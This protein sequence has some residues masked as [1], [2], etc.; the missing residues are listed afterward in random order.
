[1]ISNESHKYVGVVS[2]YD[3]NKLMTE[4]D[5]FE[6]GKTYTALVEFDVMFGYKF[7]NDTKFTV[8]GQATSSY[9]QVFERKICFTV[10]S[11]LGD[12][13]S[14]GVLNA[15]DLIELKK[16]LLKESSNEQ[17][18]L[19]GDGNVNLLDFVRLKKYIAGAET[20]LG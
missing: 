18:D 20:K 4:D 7:M 6:I 13:S 5:I 14:D 1:M 12:I 8:N 11:A 10:T 19:N 17:L 2:W 9:G 16:H 15:R 3:G